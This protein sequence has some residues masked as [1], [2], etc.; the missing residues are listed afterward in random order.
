MEMN[1]SGNESL[2]AKM[3][4]WAKNRRFSNIKANLEGH[5]IPTAYT[6]PGEDVP[7]I[8]DATGV[9]LGIKS[10]FE[11]AMKSDDNERIIRKWKLLS[12]LAEMRNGKL[13]LFA[14]KG[15]KAFVMNVV[16]ERNLHANVESI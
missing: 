6:K 13:Y 11:V 2:R 9:K 1:E 14:P 10:Y 5:E 4:H 7:Y 8:P 3:V 16:K 12:T 15:H